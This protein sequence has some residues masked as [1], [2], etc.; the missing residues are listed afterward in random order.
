LSELGIG[1]CSVVVLTQ[2]ARGGGCATSTEEPQPEVTFHDVGKAEAS[3]S[4]P[5]T[6][7]SK[8]AAAAT[9]GA[10]AA[11]RHASADVVKAIGKIQSQVAQLAVDIETHKHEPPPGLLAIASAQATDAVGSTLCVVKSLEQQLAE[12]TE[13]VGDYIAIFKDPV[14]WS[15]SARAAVIG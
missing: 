5:K 4:N 8:L 9:T 14:T 1:D 6:K 7:S 11:T 3:G 13:K 12:T 10:A 15:S 2:R